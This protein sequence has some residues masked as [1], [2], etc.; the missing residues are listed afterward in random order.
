MTPRSLALAGCGLV[1]LMG[2]IVLALVTHQDTHS[3]ANPPAVPASAVARL[4]ALARGIGTPGAAT[5]TGRLAAK[6]SVERQ[7]AQLFFVGFDG[8]DTKP[9]LKREWGAI[10][11][12]PSNTTDAGQVKRLT[13]SLATPAK[14]GRVPALV[15]AAEPAT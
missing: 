1:V 6:M 10:L 3:R 7:V 14:K 4:D 9:A 12:R 5:P 11:V 2:C 8:F 15:T 13:Y